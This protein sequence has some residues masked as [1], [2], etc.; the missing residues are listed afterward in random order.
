MFNSKKGVSI[1]ERMPPDCVLSE[2]DGP[3]VTIGSRVAAPND[4]T[5]V[6][7]KLTEVWNVGADQV[8]RRIEANFRRILE[9][10][11]LGYTVAARKAPH[12]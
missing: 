12:R 1:I 4:V 3:F 11:K 8:R 7:E 5:I 2:T 10:I 9:P 6:E